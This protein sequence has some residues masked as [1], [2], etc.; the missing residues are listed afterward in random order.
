[1]NHTPEGTPIWVRLDVDPEEVLLIV[2][3]AGPGIADESKASVFG[4]F[5]RESTDG[6]GSGLGL[7]LISQFAEL[8]GGRAWV[9]DRSGGG[10]SFKVLLPCKPEPQS[11][12]GA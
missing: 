7:Y 1:M 3:D 9:E 4:A 11:D 2:E 5:H 6:G 8:H 12:V 10:A